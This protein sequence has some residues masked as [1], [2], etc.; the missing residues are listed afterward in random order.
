[1]WERFKFCLFIIYSL[2]NHFVELRLNIIAL[3]ML[4]KYFTTEENNQPPDI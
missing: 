3:H 4:A 1:M 2:L